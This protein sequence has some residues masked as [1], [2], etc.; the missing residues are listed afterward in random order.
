MKITL[1]GGGSFA[2]TKG[3][4]CDFLLDEFFDG[5]EICIMDINPQALDM[6]YRLGEKLIALS[7]DIKIKLTKTTDLKEAL[8]GADYV[9]LTVSI[10]GLEPEL[11]DHRI[12]R[13][14]GFWNI[15]GHDIGPAGFGRTIRHVPYMIHLAH[16]MEKYC[17]NA[18]LLNLTNP[19]V[20]NTWSVNRY[21]SIKCFGFCHGV[22]GH[23]KSVLPL[24]GANSL[25][26]VEFI[27]A[28]IDHCSW[29]LE[30]KVNGKDA[31]EIMREKRLIE[32]AWRK[33]AIAEVDD[34]FAGK[35]KERLRFII[36]DMIGYFPGIGD[37][38]I[39]E[40]LPQFLKNDFVRKYWDMRYDRTWERPDSLRIYRE[41]VEN[42]L[43][44]KSELKIEPTGEII[45]KVIAAFGG[46]GG[47]VDVLN[48]PN[49]GQIPNLPEGAIVETLCK[50]DST[51]IHPVC[52][53]NLPAPVHNIVSNALEHEMMY[54]EAAFKW[55]KSLAVAALSTDPL[56]N[57]FIHTRDMVD[58]Y[59][60][61]AES[62]FEGINL[63]VKPKDWS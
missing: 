60:A 15:K 49:V 24:I 11:E 2:W 54:A 27:T 42:W 26:E 5:A 46:K 58:E 51:G 62:A 17:P 45:A 34:P 20:A 18:I 22:I 29:L 23:L 7:P 3:L 40:F 10:G 35:S 16:Q 8:I 47:F 13:K 4:L 63:R 48:A 9:T 55:N 6:V 59:F 39:C 52:A 14:Y 30:L 19:L 25:D 28:G 57:D 36:W 43:S 61:L 33:E 31:F 53:G 32:A 12:G 41:R 50:V 38:H 56:V 44:G 37:L 21:T 1:V